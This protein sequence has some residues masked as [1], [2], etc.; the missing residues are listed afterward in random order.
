MDLD[1]PAVDVSALPTAERY[2]QIHLKSEGDKLLLTLPKTQQREITP[3]DWI[4]IDLELKQSLNTLEKKWQGLAPVHLVAEDRLLDARQLQNLAELLKEGDLELTC[5][6]TSRRQTAVAAATAGYSVQQIS[7][8]DSLAFSPEAPVIFL[9]EPLYLKHTVRSGVEVRYAGTVVVLGDVNPG[10]EI[11]ADGDILI[12]G[13]LRGVAHAGAKGNRLGRIMALKLEA[14]QLRI[15]D[16]VARVP[17]PSKP[18]FTPEVAYI[19]AEGICIMEAYQF[20]KTHRFEEA[21]GWHP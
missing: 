18:Q 8:Q 5:I 19:G 20:A 6:H 16:L 4:Q 9:C 13:T 11:V 15:A 14:T 1:P 2:L 17:A 12:W 10:A 21:E 3:E 7:P